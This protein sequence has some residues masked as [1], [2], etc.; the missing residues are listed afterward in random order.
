M[1]DLTKVERFNK[2]RIGVQHMQLIR[3]EADLPK[4]DACN[5][6]VLTIPDQNTAH[7]PWCT[8]KKDCLAR[9][10]RSHTQGRSDA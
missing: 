4:C 10:L 6:D 5:F 3:G 7:W 9:N 2:Q 8:D 1:D